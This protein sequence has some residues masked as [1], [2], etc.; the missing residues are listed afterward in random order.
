M[1]RADGEAVAAMKKKLKEEAAMK[2]Q[3]DAE[4]AEARAREAAMR[5]ADG[6]A[7]VGP[8]SAPPRFPGGHVRC[9]LRCAGT[10]Q[11]FISSFSFQL[12]DWTGHF[13]YFSF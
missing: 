13:T 10:F 11:L 4:A 5:R 6:V 12:L 3:A 7:A 1:R 9:A 8:A 2:K